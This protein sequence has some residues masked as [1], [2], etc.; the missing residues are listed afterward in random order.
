MQVF[1]TGATGF[2]GQVLVRAMRGRGWQ[3]TALVRDPDAAAGRWLAG[4]GVRLLRGDVTQPAGLPNR[5]LLRQADGTLR[6]A[7][8]EAGVDFLDGS[9][10]ALFVDLDN[11]GDVD[12]A[13]DLGQR[14]ALLE[15]DGRGRFKE[16]FSAVALDLR[17]GGRHA[18]KARQRAVE[19]LECASWIVPCLVQDTQVRVGLGNER[20]EA[21]VIQ[22]DLRGLFDP[23]VVRESVRQIAQARRPEDLLQL[24]FAKVT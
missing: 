24:P 6:E 22:L 23:Q 3:V 12:L 17:V 11:D 19:V 18:D 21:G 1:L 16:R 8:R 20:S 5:L 4:Q 14:L 15:N 13:V 2:I 9:R 10:A 7:A